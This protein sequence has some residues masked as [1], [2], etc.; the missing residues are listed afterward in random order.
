MKKGLLLLFLCWSYDH[1]HAQTFLGFQCG[2]PLGSMKRRLPNV[3]FGR[4]HPGWSDE[5][6]QFF[7]VR[8]AFVG[9]F[10]VNFYDWRVTY[11]HILLDGS[12]RS[13]SGIIKLRRIV[14]GTDDDL[15]TSEFVRWIP[16]RPLP[17]S[18][19]QKKYGP[20]ND[21]GVNDDMAPYV[22]WNNGVTAVLGANKKTVLYLERACSAEELSEPW[23][24]MPEV[25]KDY[26]K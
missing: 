25:V 20:A 12:A 17:L 9:S 7:R 4:E 6:E 11:R 10:F 18:E 16:Q 19:V 3:T 1:L 22:A 24:R 2:E 14:E 13:E 5:Y 26:A 8:G 21:R 23:K 15:L